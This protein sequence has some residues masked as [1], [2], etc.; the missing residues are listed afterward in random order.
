MDNIS[1]K[2][3]VENVER[4]TVRRRNKKRASR[5]ELKSSVEGVLVWGMGK[6]IKHLGTLWQIYMIHVC[7]VMCETNIDVY[8]CMCEDV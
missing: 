1:G 5:G 7:L 4:Q 3:G 8:V 6:T 2:I